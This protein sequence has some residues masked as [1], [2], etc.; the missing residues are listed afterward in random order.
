MTGTKNVE[1]LNR[2]MGSQPSPLLS[3]ED[4]SYYWDPNPPLSS[5]WK[6]LVINGIPTLSS[7]WKILVITCNSFSFFI[8]S[9]TKTITFINESFSNKI[10]RH[11]SWKPT[12]GNYT[13]QLA[14][15]RCDLN[16]IDSLFQSKS[17]YSI[18]PEGKKW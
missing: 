10:S 14:L 12:W 3:V 1:G 15:Y 16:Y 6:I 2:L 8:Q 17:C 4:I 11:V 9:K 7:Q 13:C 18:I 5:Q